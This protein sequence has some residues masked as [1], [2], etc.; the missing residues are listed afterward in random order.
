MGIPPTGQSVELL[1]CSIF[2]LGIDRLV[3]EEILYFDAATL[4]RQLGVLPGA[5]LAAGPDAAGDHIGIPQQWLGGSG[6][7]VDTEA[8]AFGRQLLAS[9]A[10]T[11]Q[12]HW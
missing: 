9:G 5:A 3:D 11:A 10:E 7:V 8:T 1:T 4:L 2:T 6:Y 12:I